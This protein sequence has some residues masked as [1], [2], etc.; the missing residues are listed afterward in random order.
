MR[1]LAWLGKSIAFRGTRF[2]LGLTCLL[3]LASPVWAAH[4]AHIPLP[5]DLSGTLRDVPFKI[6]VPVNWNGTL[7]VYTHGAGFYPE[8]ELVPQV[9]PSE[10]GQDLAA[11]RHEFEASLLG[12]GYALAASALRAAGYDL[13]DD[14][15]LNMALT[16]YFRSRVGNPERILLWG[17]S[18]GGAVSSRMI[19][20][21]PFYDGAII[22]T[23]G[24]ISP[25]SVDRLLDVGLAYWA[26]MGTWPDDAFGPLADLK[27][28][29]D[30]MTFVT[31]IQWPY[32]ISPTENNIGQWEFIRLVMGLNPDEFWGVD[33]LSGN[34]NFGGLM[35]G[36]TCGRAGV[37]A[38]WGG[39]VAQNLDRTYSLPAQDIADLAT[40]FGIPETTIQDWLDAMNGQR[41][42]ADHV[43]RRHFTI[44][45]EP[46]GWFPRPVL[47]M[48]NKFDGLCPV[49]RES[50]YYELA[51]QTG[52]LG[53][54]VQVYTNGVGHV[55]YS[56]DQLQSALDAMQNWLSK[57][58][59]P[60]ASFFPE[61]Q[62]F[63]NSFVPPPYQYKP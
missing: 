19:E 44:W 36:A 29:L 25:A 14:Y 28:N 18:L 35:W 1:V 32:F 20:K 41:I 43:A 11:A 27:D 30:W 50:G 48:H 6:K 53:N 5:A 16:A 4:R 8:P 34:S 57:G 42:A 49:A 46:S 45:G 52:S 2:W 3:L 15:E 58:I 61:S 37:E 7:L 9:V 23:E 12:K 51:E 22:L 10:S 33:E 17:E 26:A 63:D 47:R 39:P 60:D 56:S 21:Y 62:G 59:K 13:K 54:L 24:G 31:N 38:A 55:V 40:A